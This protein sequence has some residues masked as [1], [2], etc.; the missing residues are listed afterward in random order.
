[1]SIS[2]KA[3]KNVSQSAL[4]L[5]VSTVIVKII[6]ALFKIPLATNTFLG[7]LGFGYF[8]VSYDLFTPFYTLAISG[9]PSAISHIIAEFLAQKRFN[10]IKQTFTLTKKLFILFG[11]IFSVGFSLVSI[12]LIKLTDNSGNSL[13]SLFA[14]IPSVFL[15]FIISV[16][17]GY[18][19][20]FANMNPTA[21]SKIIESLC[22]LF[23]GLGFAFAVIKITENPAY[24]AGASML[25]IT[26][27]NLACTVYLFIKFKL[28][29]NLIS[30]ND[31]AQSKP[32]L[33]NKKTLR[34]I[35]SLALPIAFSS[36]VLNAVSVIDAI[37]VRFL[38]EN[39]SQT[40]FENYKVAIESY[41]LN[42]LLPLE[43]ENLPTYL[44]GL[45][46]KAFTLSN[47]IPTLTLSFGV[48]AL[49]IIS[50]YWAKKDINEV[51][52][53]FNTTI[54]W[55]SLITLPAGM[56]YITVSK[57]IMNLL[58][59][60]YSSVNIGGNLLMLFGITAIFAGFAIPITN[61]L[62][63]LNCQFSA[64]INIIFG[65]IIKIVLNV[66]LIPNPK[67]NIYGAAIST[68]VC[69]LV[70]LIAH[71]YKI[72]KVLGKKALIK[73]NVL[74]PLL[75][76]ICSSL[77]AYFICLIS[78]S[79]MVTI[80]GIFVAI[81]AYVVVTFGFGTLTKDDFLNLPKGEKL[82]FLAKKLRFF[83]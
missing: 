52:S 10:D 74:K 51:K 29:G 23:L 26:V 36:L 48:G 21:V 40:L 27:G 8:S 70:I 5:L 62:Q 19:E 57:P 81:I 9:L 49:P 60:D 56:A 25:G 83:K 13:Y 15:C 47:L 66:I 38:L 28:N 37:T 55:I 45:R 50:F 24:A 64:F 79:K 58:Y 6:G 82:Y 33:E 39:D 14:I 30:E 75:A 12:P 77:S 16:Y 11:I 18:F 61:I 43:I 7:D 67:F 73:S 32:V 34:L 42:S 80:C 69:Y 2:N 59:S 44:Y 71:S 31:F 63:S 22:K 54:K 76:A 78:E 4:V 3:T 35:L 65:A 72:Y 17:R 53:S 46:S 20:G 68:A 1:M 41:N